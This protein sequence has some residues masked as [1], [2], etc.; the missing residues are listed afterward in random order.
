MPEEV[1]RMGKWAPNDNVSF[2]LRHEFGHVFSAKFD[3]LKHALSDDPAFIQVFKSDFS[4]LSASKLN[5]LRLSGR[6]LANVRDEVFADMYAHVSA[7][8]AG[9]TA[10]SHYS[11]KL[12]ESFPNCLKYLEE[13]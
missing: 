3:A 11:I 10:N 4:S 7:Q 6:S 8:R 9:V 5:E 13:F 12:K 1:M 2:A